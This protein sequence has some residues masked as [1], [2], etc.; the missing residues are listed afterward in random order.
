[1]NE[2]DSGL[3]KLADFAS[4]PKDDVRPRWKL[5]RGPVLF[6][7]VASEREKVVEVQQL[8]RELGPVLVEMKLL[9]P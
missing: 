2:N 5:Q 8:L 6:V 7:N 4:A 3:R 1:M 9:D